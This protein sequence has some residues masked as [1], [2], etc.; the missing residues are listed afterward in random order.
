MGFGKISHCSHCVVIVISTRSG[1]I[2]SIHVRNR[3]ISHAVRD[4]R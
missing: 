2:L 3:K 1:A 4:D